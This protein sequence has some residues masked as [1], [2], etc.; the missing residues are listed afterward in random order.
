ME[1]ILESESKAAVV[2]SQK[3]TMPPNRSKV[4]KIRVEP[5][6]PVEPS[7]DDSNSEVY[8]V[9]EA[10]SAKIISPYA[11]E[12][13]GDVAPKGQAGKEV[14][15]APDKDKVEV[16]IP[17]KFKGKSLEEVITSYTELESHTTKVAQRNAELEKSSKKGEPVVAS[18]EK[19]EVTA[20]IVDKFYTDPK[21]A[22]EDIISLTRTAVTKELDSKKVED[23]KK[24]REKDIADT[25]A[26]VKE[27]RKDILENPSF[28]QMVDGI[29]AVTPGE[30]NLEKYQ[31]A[32]KKFDEAIGAVAA[33]TEEGLKKKITE[34]NKEK[35]SAAL[36]S[37]SAADH[38]KGSGKIWR[39]SEINRL[40]TKDPSGYVKKQ[41]EIA[42]ALQEGRV[43]ED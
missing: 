32:I 23:T 22:L 1:N 30:T 11:E 10:S 12:N 18:P 15:D 34:T 28:S 13:E 19:V 17:E 26:W 21:G 40:I 43:R 31:A 33:K 27:N 2:E 16:V 29:A 24:S 5:S 38:A 4:S 35:E 39:R 36:P 7:A 6:K 20:E 37:G 9:L 14:V 42:K 8:K 3:R 25:I 41:R